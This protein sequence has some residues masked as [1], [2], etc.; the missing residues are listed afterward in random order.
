PDRSP[1]R[2]A[3][4]A[5]RRRGTP[6]PTARPRRSRAGACASARRAPSRP[7]RAWRRRS[8]PARAA[9]PRAARP[10]SSCRCR[11]SPRKSRTL[12]AEATAADHRRPVQDRRRTRGGGRGRGRPPRLARYLIGGVGNAPRPTAG[13]TLVMYT[14]AYR[15][16]A[17]RLAHDVKARLVSPLDGMKASALLGAQLVLVVGR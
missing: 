2:R 12:A 15:P 6:R 16:E 11:R 9:P 10:A 8:G 5:P 13:Q 3:A 14:G 7:A 1:R 4:R 17:L